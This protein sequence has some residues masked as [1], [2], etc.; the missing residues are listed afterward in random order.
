MKKF[1][2]TAIVAVASV[3]ANA[4]VWVGGEVGYN[5]SKITIDGTKANAENTVTILPEIGYSLNENWDV[6]VAIGYKHGD[7]KE[8]ITGEF[9][10]TNSFILNP[11]V[12]Y[13]YAKVGDLKFF[14]DGG[15]S[16]MNT[17]FCGDDDNMNSW[18]LGFKPGL[19][20][21]VSPKTTL[22]AHLGDLSYGFSKIGDVKKN[23]FNLDL[24]NSITFGVYF[25]L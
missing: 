19:A 11:Y 6:A 5:T 25:S 9:V 13:S 16:Y 7:E 23:S 20:Y 15:F 8:H 17:H 3:A 22:V 18:S 10:G 12:R 24:K 1:I 14:V 4:Q 2:L 21:S